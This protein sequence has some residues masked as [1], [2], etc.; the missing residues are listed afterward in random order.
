MPNTFYHDACNVDA[1]M[2]PFPPELKD[3]QL[4]AKDG[5]SFFVA[6]NDE[7]GVLSMPHSIMNDNVAI[8]YNL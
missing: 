8:N 2:S 7:D 6:K 5:L 3:K 1:R 4:D